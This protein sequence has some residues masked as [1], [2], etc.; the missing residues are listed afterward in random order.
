MRRATACYRWPAV[1]GASPA[2][3]GTMTSSLD[4]CDATPALAKAWPQLSTTSRTADAK[5]AA[6]A[7]TNIQ[8]AQRRC[9]VSAVARAAQPA[10]TRQQQQQQPHLATFAPSSRTRLRL[11]PGAVPTPQTQRAAATAVPALLLSTGPPCWPWTCAATASRSIEPCDT[12]ILAPA[13]CVA[14]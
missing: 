5:S 8:K 13:V 11:R 6:S 14:N 9:R 10:H 4:V 7:Y 1:C 12:G 3:A 2:A